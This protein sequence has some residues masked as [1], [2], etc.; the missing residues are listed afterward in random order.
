M[1]TTH[2]T[3]TPAVFSSLGAGAGRGKAPQE[4]TPRPHYQEIADLE[5]AERINQRRSPNR[6]ERVIRGVQAA[7]ITIAAISVIATLPKAVSQV[8]HDIAQHEQRVP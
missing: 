1:A 4:R 8:A 3:N 6:T 2:Q 7:L 5:F